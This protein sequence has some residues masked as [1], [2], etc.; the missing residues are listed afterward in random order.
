MQ[1]IRNKMDYPLILLA[2][3]GIAVSN[4]LNLGTYVLVL[5]VLEFLIVRRR[6]PKKA[7]LVLLLLFAFFYM[8]S[9]MIWA[10]FSF[11][12]LKPFVFAFLWGAIYVYS[13][14]KSIK[15]IFTL[16][17]V[18][19]LGMTIHGLANFA[20]NTLTGTKMITG[21]SNDV[22]TKQYSSATGQAINFTLFIALIF[23]T[24]FAQKNFKL[25]IAGLA[26]FV[27]SLLYDI[28]L[29]GRSFLVL[30]MLSVFIGIISYIVLLINDSNIKDK[31]RLI[32]ILISLIILAVLAVYFYQ[33]NYFGLKTW[34]ESSYLFKRVE[35]YDADQLRQDERV[36][37]KIKYMQY[38]FDH[39][40]GGN[41]ISKTEGVGYAHELWLDIYDDAGIFAFS[42]MLGYTIVSVKTL[43]RVVRIKCL[44]LQY[45]VGLIEYEFV[46]LAQFWVEPIYEGAPLLL[47]SYIMIDAALSRYLDD[48]VYK[49]K[50]LE[51]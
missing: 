35:Y 33:N 8:L 50:C 20:Y 31:T 46:M 29:G 11:N 40:L 38:F 15:S 28:Q 16:V 44:E 21:L 34:Y 25:K 10:N 18:L 51:K 17:M 32:Y 23:W 39:L 24:V 41:Q 7:Q 4:V 43:M 37:R 48:Y 9:T 3:L 45:K 19:G 5:F 36:N 30:A 13:K 12:S 47:A 22:F 42:F 14:N 6:L 2:I 27:C 1:N 26:V 49:Q